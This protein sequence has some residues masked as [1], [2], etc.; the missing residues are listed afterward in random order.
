MHV[1]KVLDP[2]AWF[3]EISL[4]QSLAAL[5]RTCKPFYEPAMDLLWAELD[6]MEPLLSCV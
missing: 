3:R 2:H 5:A 6:G 4:T 1:D